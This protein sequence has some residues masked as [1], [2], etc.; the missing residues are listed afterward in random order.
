MSDI[1]TKEN[2]QDVKE[3]I[4]DGRIK[5]LAFSPDLFVDLLRC[6]KPILVNMEGIP[7]DA[8]LLAVNFDP[9]SNMM[10]LKLV[11]KEF[12]KTK[13]GEVIPFVEDGTITRID[14]QCDCKDKTVDDVTKPVNVDP[15]TGKEIDP[16]TRK[17]VEEEVPKEE[18]EK[19]DD[20]SDC[21][22]DMKPIPE[23][24]K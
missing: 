24:S 18:E 21:G 4:Q 16:I 10:L 9:R 14:C 3:L 20:A 7:E 6:K 19:K 13:E 17:E 1:V 15:E 12:D 23:E 11:S 8:I 2:I 22:A 5:L